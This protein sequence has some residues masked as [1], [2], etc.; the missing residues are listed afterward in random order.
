MN[1]LR[2]NRGFFLFRNRIFKLEQL[3]RGMEVMKKMIGSLSLLIPKK[4]NLNVMSQILKQKCL[5]TAGV[6]LYNRT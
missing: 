2:L 6:P 3:I 4:T 1:I 5:I